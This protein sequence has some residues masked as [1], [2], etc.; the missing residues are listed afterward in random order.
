MNFS[1]SRQLDSTAVQLLAVVDSVILYQKDMERKTPRSSAAASIEN[2]VINYERT[3][4]DDWKYLKQLKDETDGESK[5]VR[6]SF[7]MVNF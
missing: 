7:E 5:K 3:T 4:E 1:R 2:K 6:I